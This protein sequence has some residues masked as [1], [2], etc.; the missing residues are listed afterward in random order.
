MKYSLT[1]GS[2]VIMVTSCPMNCGLTG[3]CKYCQPQLYRV[4]NGISGNDS[5]DCSPGGNSSWIPRFDGQYSPE[6]RTE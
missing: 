1:D 3:G 5:N 6:E 4:Q 2:V